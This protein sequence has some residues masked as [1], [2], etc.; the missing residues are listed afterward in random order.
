MKEKYRVSDESLSLELKDLKQ[1]D[2][3]DIWQGPPFA[4][5]SGFRNWCSRYEWEPQTVEQDLTVVTRHGNSLILAANGHWRPVVEV[6]FFGSLWRAETSEINKKRTVVDQGVENW[7]RYTDLTAKIWGNPAWVGAAGDHGFPESPVQGHWAKPEGPHGY[8]F[9]AS[10][11]TPNQGPSDPVVLLTMAVADFT[12]EP[13]N[14]A[15]SVVSLDFL[16]P[17]ENGRHG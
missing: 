12:W 2:W 9:R 4:N 15:G 17:A 13:G 14:M 6:S 7:R 8:P 16:P 11:W 1:V 10:L 3:P 5:E